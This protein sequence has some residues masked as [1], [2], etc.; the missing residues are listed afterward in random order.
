MKN[1]EID[2]VTQYQFEDDDVE[3]KRKFEAMLITGSNKFSKRFM[4]GL[5]E[6]L[7]DCQA[8][9]I[10]LWEEIEVAVGLLDP[11][12]KKDFSLTYHWPTRSFTVQ[13]KWDSFPDIELL[14]HAKEALVQ[15]LDFPAAYA[16]RDAIDKIKESQEE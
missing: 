3:L 15:H 11:A 14:N 13:K 16:V 2:G 8:R 1:V 7:A 12:L 9:T 5:I 4:D 6:S 10:E